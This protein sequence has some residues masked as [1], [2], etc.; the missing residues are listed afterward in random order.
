[1][2]KKK[3]INA[4]HHNRTKAVKCF[5][6]HVTQMVWNAHCREEMFNGCQVI[7]MLPGFDENLDRK[8]PEN[9]GLCETFF[10]SG[11]VLHD[12]IAEHQKMFPDP[13]L[14]IITRE[15]WDK[16][17]ADCPSAKAPPQVKQSKKKRQTKPAKV[18]AP[19]RKSRP[20][21]PVPK[22]RGAVGACK[23]MGNDCVNKSSQ[24]QTTRCLECTIWV[25]PKKGCSIANGTSFV[26]EVCW[27]KDE[28]ESSSNEEVEKPPPPINDAHKKP[29]DCSSS[30]DS[31]TE[32]EEE[33]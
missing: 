18:V 20:T 27:N 23:V 15:E 10:L 12:G 9:D 6:I 13:S 25:H 7:G 11:E 32:G 33:I 17:A 5:T 14:Q 16:K 1:M 3:V 8:C 28:S 19:K 24:N 29:I 21:S 31:S 22:G 30:D 2:L 26:C 4:D